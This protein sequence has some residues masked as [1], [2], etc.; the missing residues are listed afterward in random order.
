MKI[1]IV[2]NAEWLERYTSEKKLE[3]INLLIDSFK[4]EIIFETNDT[5]GRIAICP[6]IAFN[7]IQFFASCIAKNSYFYDQ[8]WGIDVWVLYKEEII[9][10]IDKNLETIFMTKVGKKE[11]LNNIDNLLSQFRHLFISNNLLVKSTR[12]WV[13]RG[14]NPRLKYKSL[15]ISKTGEVNGVM[16]RVI[17]DK[18]TSTILTSFPISDIGYA[19]PN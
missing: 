6:D 11:L 18:K 17:M 7:W 4:G 10:F 1:L 3:S 16:I 19:G 9:R 5:T 15:V 8:I 14:I 13:N 12:S 2:P